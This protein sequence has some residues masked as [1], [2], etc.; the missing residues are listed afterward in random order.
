MLDASQIRQA[1][2]REERNSQEA[3]LAST[4]T[5]DSD[6]VLVLWNRAAESYIAHVRG[7]PAP[8]KET[9]STGSALEV[10]LAA[11]KPETRAHA[12]LSKVEQVR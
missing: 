5:V 1:P 11:A 9:F 3:K 10:S 7:L 8:S 4:A 6:S 2:A 12:Q